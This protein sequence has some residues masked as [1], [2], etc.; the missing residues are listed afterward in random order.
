MVDPPPNTTKTIRMPDFAYTARDMNGQRVSGTISAGSEREAINLISGQSLFPVE[1]TTTSPDAATVSHRRVRAQLMANTYAQLAALQRSGVP[2][3]R[4]IKLLQEQSS[5]AALKAVLTDVHD[6]VED[7]E[8]LAD[9]MARYPRAFSEICVNM[10]RAVSEGG[11]LEEA[12]DRVAQF[13]EHQIDLRSRTMGALLYPLILACFGTVIVT[14]LIVFVVPQFADLFDQLRA[15][16]ELP[17]LT[18]ALLGFSAMIRNWGWLIVILI[19]GGVFLLRSRLATPEGRRTSDLVKLRVPLFGRIFKS[20][21][22]ARFCRV[23][24]TLLRNGVPILRS[25]DISREAAGNKILSEAIEQASENITQGESLATP[26]SQSGHFPRE[27]VEMISVAEE[28]N[29]LDKVLVDVAD[30]L[31]RR[32]GRTLELMVRLLE[33]IVLLLMAIVVLFVALSLLL[34]IIKMG[35]TI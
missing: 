32:T 14:G 5:N 8:P 10:V 20:L 6:R 23:L 7:G 1:V 9:A 34:P 26:L 4:S 12:L 30:G 2:L 29:T 33:P 3:L 24:G 22:I 17:W 21:A 19:V 18:E 25:L 11:F 27:V 28:S 15:R 13:T 16:G 31:E 35:Q